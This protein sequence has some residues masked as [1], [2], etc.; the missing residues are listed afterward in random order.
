MARTKLK[1]MERNQRRGWDND[2]NKGEENKSVSLK[3]MRLPTKHTCTSN[4]PYPSVEKVSK[5]IRK[6]RS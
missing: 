3:L 1:L 2:N 4:D 5:A 6:K